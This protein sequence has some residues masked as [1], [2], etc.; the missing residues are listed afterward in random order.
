[1]RNLLSKL[2]AT[3]EVHSLQVNYTLKFFRMQPLRAPL[4]G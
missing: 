4:L 2:R 3:L 1:M